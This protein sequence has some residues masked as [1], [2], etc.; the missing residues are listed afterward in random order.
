MEGGPEF[1]HLGLEFV[2]PIRCRFLRPEHGRSP[3]G[4][5]FREVHGNPRFSVISEPDRPLRGLRL[6]PGSLWADAQPVAK[7]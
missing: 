7:L 2:D 4:M 5:D 3:G 6:F 1:F